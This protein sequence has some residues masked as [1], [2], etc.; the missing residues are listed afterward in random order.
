MKAAGKRLASSNPDSGAGENLI[1][2][3]SEFVIRL[4]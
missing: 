2:G 3:N 4:V 1:G